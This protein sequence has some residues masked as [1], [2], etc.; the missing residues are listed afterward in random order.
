MGKNEPVRGMCARRSSREA[1]D[2]CLSLVPGRLRISAFP[3]DRRETDSLSSFLCQVGRVLGAG[4]AAS[5][6]DG[7]EQDQREC[8][9]SGN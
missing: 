7:I 6:R 5:A 1:A 2:E 4:V 3:K 8:S 9:K